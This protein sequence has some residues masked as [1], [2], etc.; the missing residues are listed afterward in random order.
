MGYTNIYGIDLSLAVWLVADDYDFSPAEK[1]ISATALLKPTRQ[2]ILANRMKDEQIVD[3]S[4]RIS[5]RLGHAI[6][7]SIER[8]WKE[9]HAKALAIL[10]IPQNVIDRV[11]I[12]PD[13]A[14]LTSEDIPVFLEVRGSRQIDGWTISGKLDMALNWRLKDI[15]STSV[16]TYI[17]G[18][19]DGDYQLQGS[20]YR[21]LHQDKVKEDEIDI[22]FVFTDHQKAMVNTVP[23]YPEIKV[24]S[25]TLPLMSLDETE[26]W[27]R[28][29]LYDLDRYKNAPEEA[30]PRCTDEELWRSNPVWKYYSDP[31]KTDGKS[32]KNFDN[33]ADAQRHLTEKGKGVI[34]HV[35]G[36]VKACGY[37]PAFSSCKQK[38]E[39]EHD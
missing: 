34:K 32:T 14:T 3:L 21:W 4:S 17:M 31:A 6:H 33:A 7:D 1:A 38:D 13:P 5:S 39:Y 23:G 15:K 19:K 25:Y 2:I 9:Q 22:Q 29:K 37:C 26:T 30:L 16:Y 27:I 11:K 28:N 10:N 18:R 24:V 8:S 36:K 35:P 12:N 20:F